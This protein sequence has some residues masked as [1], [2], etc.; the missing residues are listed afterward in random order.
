M[1]RGRDPLMDPVVQSASMVWN[2]RNSQ[3]ASDAAQTCH[4][5]SSN[6]LQTA[7]KGEML[8]FL[9]ATACFIGES[10]LGFHPSE[11]CNKH[12]RSG[13]AMAWFLAGC[14]PEQIMTNG[15][16][17]SCAFLKCMRKQ[18]LEFS[19]GMTEII[20]LPAFQALPTP[21]AGT[22]DPRENP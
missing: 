12:V 1:K 18:V 22:T 21:I 4:C 19:K 20:L 3:G 2:L 9:R 13:A 8:D 7:K 6:K 11:M 15:R 14:R 10:Q 17:L 5:F 16:W